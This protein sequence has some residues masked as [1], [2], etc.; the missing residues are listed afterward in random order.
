MKKQAAL[1]ILL[2]SL[3]M[4]GCGRNEGPEQEQIM[5][6]MVEMSLQQ[7][8]SA[9]DLAA[10]A[11]ALAASATAAAPTETPAEAALPM[12]PV[13][14]STPLDT[15][16]APPATSAPLPASPTTVPTAAGPAIVFLPEGLF[17]DGDRAIIMQK[18]VNP[19]V[20][21]HRDLEGHPALISITIERYSGDPTY[22]FQALAVFGGG[23]YIGWL[24][25]ATAGV[26]DWW[27]PDCMGPCPVS[28]S[29]RAAYP[30]IMA[31][32]EP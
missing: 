21:Y 11:T 2:V 19:F 8:R 17:S 6:T 20:H 13:D 31:I 30:E 15:P 4:A 22:P 3:L 16:T 23:A 10:A 9:D 24:M 28:D 5:E 1:I 25:P 26:L 12:L 14:T 18:V 7:T 29:F 27:A 32:L